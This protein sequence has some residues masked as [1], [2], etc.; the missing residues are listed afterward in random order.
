[1][2][3]CILRS[4]RISS[5]LPT[6]KL[7]QTIILLES[8]SFYAP[9]PCCLTS[10]SSVSLELCLSISL[11][12]MRLHRSKQLS[13]S[14][15]LHPSRLCTKCALLEIPSN[16]SYYFSMHCIFLIYCQYLLMVLMMLSKFKAS[17]KFR[18][19]KTS[20]SY[21]IP[22]VSDFFALFADELIFFARSYASS[23]WKLYL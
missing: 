16:V 1:M 15:Y 13:I 18:I 22:S 6:S 11:L 21:S 2:I 23:T 5:S 8:K 20:A 9:Y 10:F 12:L 19:F 14:M 4:P 3:I 17:L 7:Y